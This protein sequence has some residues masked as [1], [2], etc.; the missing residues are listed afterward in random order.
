MRWSCKTT[1]YLASEAAAGT[2]APFLC[3]LVAREE[4]LKVKEQ[5]GGHK[6][7]AQGEN[8]EWGKAPPK[9]IGRRK[10]DKPLRCIVTGGSSGIGEAICR[11]VSKGSPVCLRLC[12]HTHLTFSRTYRNRY[13]KRVGAKFRSVLSLL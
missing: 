2:S 8:S 6:I 9:N 11:E 3:F 13:G 4:S 7:V 10:L 1:G 5:G 12:V